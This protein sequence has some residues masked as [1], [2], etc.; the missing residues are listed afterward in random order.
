MRRR[1][2]IG[3]VRPALAAA[4]DRRRAWAFDWLL[5]AAAAAA[6]VVAATSEVRAQAW[7]DDPQHGPREVQH[8]YLP[9]PS[10]ATSLPYNGDPGGYRKWLGTRG[11]VF[12]IEY[13][14]DI[15]SNLRGG[16]KTGT[17]D[18]GKLHGIV[19][20]DMGKLAGWDGLTLFANAFQIHNTGRFRRD[21]VGGIN[22]IAAIE[23]LSTTRLSELWAEQTFAGGKASIKV[24][25]LTAD[26]EF[27][28]SNLSSLFL[29]SDWPAIAAVNLPSGGAAYPFS[30]PGVRLQV[31][32]VKNVWL[33]MAV[34]NGDPAGP[35][36]GDEQVRNRHGTNFR[37]Q[38]PAF[39]IG[40]AEW[41]INCRPNDTGLAT[42]LLVGAWGHIGR[43]DDQRFAVGGALLADPAGSGT[44]ISH[45]GN[46]GVYAAIDQ[47]LYRPAG[48][49]PHDGI[50]IYTRMSIS[51]SDRNLVDRY[52]DGGIVFAGLIPQRPNDRFGAG[53]IYSRF[54]D[55]VRAFDRDQ[56]LFGTPVPVQDY[57]AS[58]EITYQAQIVPGW[59][60]Q[61][62][63]QYVWHPNGDASR[64]A[65][66]LGLR[67][68]WRF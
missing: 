63:F 30:T 68:L 39:F 57:E 41:D 24:G 42:R 59:L 2:G 52:I 13:T 36:P 23:A 26:S 15:L 66:V 67:S 12:G 49:G 44:P 35:G 10:L 58:L 6:L 61:P 65:T 54:S 46:N 31:N 27:F 22:T 25:Q 29:Q 16:T 4:G 34:L 56:I 48:G 38:D 3:Q 53:F 32:P 17:I 21:Y 14:N 9:S 43:F 11:I 45:R 47:Q 33:R 64:N 7:W 1:L 20:V 5:P 62:N 60:V 50:S 37:I 40:E 18:Q 19:T 8:G 55:S 28:Y 51:P